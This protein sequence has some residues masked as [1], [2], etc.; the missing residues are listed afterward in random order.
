MTNIKAP[1]STP[2]PTHSTTSATSAAISTLAY[3]CPDLD[4]TSYTDATGS[5]Y[6]I[7]YSTNYPS[8]NLPAVHAD[9]FEGCLR[10]CDIYVPEPSAA[11]EASCIGVSWGAGNTGGNCYLKYQTTNITTN[12]DR[13]SSGYY[14]NYTLPNSAVI[15]Q[16]STSSSSNSR[17][18]SSTHSGTSKDHAAVGV[19]VGFGVPVGLGILAGC[20]YFV[21][22][23]AKA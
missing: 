9:T 21:R 17:A 15:S 13:L 1:S 2:A 3:P 12:D 4:G 23:Q 11:N 7:Q 6:K 19:G 18:T 20:F 10:F 22:R 14:V 16:G 5:S 8:H